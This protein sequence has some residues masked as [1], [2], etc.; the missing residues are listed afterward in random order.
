MDSDTI[1]CMAGQYKR[2][3]DWIWRGLRTMG[4]YSTIKKKKIL[5]L[6]ITQ[7]NMDDIM[8]SESQRKNDKC[9]M[10]FPICE[11]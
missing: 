3:K 7:M 9:C 11:I 1:G 6:A 4:Y 5:P 8:L 10:I 2:L